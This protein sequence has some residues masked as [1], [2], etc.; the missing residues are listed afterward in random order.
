MCVQENAADRPT[1]SNVIAML[2]SDSTNLPDPKQPAYFNMRIKNEAEMASAFI[3]P[4]SENEITLLASLLLTSLLSFLIFRHGSAD[5]P[6]YQLCGNA[7]NYIAKSTYESNL[8]QL[9]HTL[10]SVASVASASGIGFSS[11]ST[12]ELPDQVWGLALCRGGSNATDCRTCLDGASTDIL[13]FCPYYKTAVIWYQHCLIRYSNQ[14]FTSDFF[15][16]SAQAIVWNTINTTGGRFP[17][18]AQNAT[19]YNFF[20]RVVNTL[21][22]NLADSAAS[23]SKSGKLYATGELTITNGFLTIYGLVLCSP[24]MSGPDCRRCLQVKINETLNTFDGRLGGQILGVRCTLS[25]DV[26]TFCHGK[27]MIR[28]S[29]VARVPGTPPPP[30]AWPGTG[31]GKNKRCIIIITVCL[32]VL[33]FFSILYL[34]CIKRQRR[35]ERRKLY[36]TQ[37][38]STFD[39]NE[40][41][42]L[43]KSEESS[44]EF[45]LFDFATIGL[46][47]NGLEIAVKR[48][49]TRSS[50]G[51]MEFKNEI[52]LIAKLQHR[53]LV[54]LL[55]CCIQGEE[56][57]LIYEYM[58]NKSLDFFLFD[59]TR[60]ATL[61]WQK[62]I[63]I[64]EGI[65]QGLLYLHKH[66][67]LRII[68]RDLKASNI[69]LDSEMN[70]KISDFGLAR[71]F[72]SNETQ[73]NTNRVVGTYGYMSPEYAS[74]G[75]FSVKSDVFSF[76]VL[77]LEIVS[78][79]R[80]A[81][82]HQYGNY[83]NLL[84]YAWEVWKEGR[85]FELI[86]PSLDGSSE[87]YEVVRCIH[88][89]LM[90]VQE[91]AADR[92]TMS[93]VI[94]MLS[95]DS[96]NLPDPKQPAYFNMRIKNEAEMASD[97][98]M[99]ASENDITFTGPEATYLC[100]TLTFKSH[101]RYKQSPTALQYCQ[102]RQVLDQ[103]LASLCRGDVNATKLPHL[104]GLCP[105]D[106]AAVICTT[107]ASQYSNQNFT[108]AFNNS[109]QVVLLNTQDIAG[110]RFPGYTQNTTIYDFFKQVV[111][112]LLSHVAD[113][114]ASNS[115]SGKLF[116]TG[117]STITNAFLTIYGLVQCAPDM[118]GPA[119]RQCLQGLISEMLR[120]FDGRRGGR[121]LG[122]WCNLRYEVY[123]FYDGNPTIR[124]S[125]VAPGD[126]LGTLQPPSTRPGTYVARR[127]SR[128]RPLCKFQPKKG[129]SWITSTTFNFDTDE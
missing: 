31:R 87:T 129:Q 19:I 25:Y 58:P 116:A 40:V 47:S 104:P 54:R 114:A 52:Q 51:L 108:S 94:A 11:A 42:K 60:G 92:P 23:K 59:Q 33:I 67:R 106:K 96:T 78:G 9:L 90:C 15:D 85:W 44:S 91:N 124:L 72:G 13:L 98:I 21:L 101:S 38:T 81:C 30:C 84:G 99:P 105:Y 110:G 4:A 119:C 103:V 24:D 26:Y 97:F 125:S 77:L 16:D 32:T 20:Y 27:P 14:N 56:K 6:I 37:P 43:W 5:L 22:S 46:L 10:P 76:G 107:T 61:D 69:L 28:L 35:A 2:S 8:R 1:M 120:R 111:N 49:S 66:S 82:F 88:V 3:V 100:L 63:T 93:N 75:L 34:L 126:L 86:D 121:I 70:P 50:Q 95:S 123:P 102:H 12:G 39:T 53:N 41:I 7:G 89:A 45:P 68:H 128:C 71:I 74:E 127:L 80:N 17:G 115:N 73:A 113:S 79:K 55:G 29:S 112:T 109:E 62:R 83:L 18:S 122:V 57:I 65:A 36:S 117:E 118:S 64:V 48:L